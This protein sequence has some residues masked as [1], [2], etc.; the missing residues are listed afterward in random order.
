M[1]KIG[2]MEDR[3]YLFGALLYHI[4]PTLMSDKPACIITINSYD[5][6]LNLLWKKY[7]SDFLSICKLNICEI[8]EWF[9]SKTLFIYDENILSKIIY[10]DESM[11]F[12]AR[13]GYNRTLNI[14]EMLSLL[15][16]R[17]NYFCP[18]E[19]GIFLGFP[20]EDVI[21]FI[22]YPHKKCL[23]SG[24]WKVYNNVDFAMEKFIQYDMAKNR[25]INSVLDGVLPSLI[26]EN[27]IKELVI[28]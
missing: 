15:K 26:I 14:N 24:Y 20:I 16:E 23:L 11:N 17:Y 28:H 7:K 13:F 19:I 12:L 8:K 6:D 9:E 25:V 10:K 21:D 5:R 4:A 22:E 2:G 1:D 27:S 3:E 18:H